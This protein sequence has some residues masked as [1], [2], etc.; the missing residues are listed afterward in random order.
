MNIISTAEQTIFHDNCFACGKKNPLSLGLTFKQ[1][2][3]KTIQASFTGNL[4]LQGYDG[5]LHGGIISTLL[6]SAMANCLLL[7]DVKGVTA[8]L[9]VRFLH[10]IP[11]TS[12]LSI[13]AWITCAVSSLYELKAEVKVN[14]KVMA[15]ARAKFMDKD[16]KTSV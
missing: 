13:K 6:D 7:K 15:K 11:C 10:S 9:R 1:I 4:N 2:D 16:V 14:G 8:D 12:K 3:D 5:I